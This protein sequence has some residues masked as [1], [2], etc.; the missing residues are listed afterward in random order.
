MGVAAHGWMFVG[1]WE[2]T[3]ARPQPRSGVD[4][5]G[6]VRRDLLPLDSASSRRHLDEIP[7]N[8]K[9]TPR[10]GHSSGKVSTPLARARRVA[11]SRSREKQNSSKAIEISPPG[12]FSMEVECPDQKCSSSSSERAIFTHLTC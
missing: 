6:C 7:Q 1:K 2:Y 3:V 9:H 4:R 10:T 12:T 11:T 5:F 8:L